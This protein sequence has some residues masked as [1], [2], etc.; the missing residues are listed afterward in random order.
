MDKIVCELKSNPLYWASLGS[1]ELF[2]SNFLG[3]IFEQYPSSVKAVLEKKIQ[4]PDVLRE[5][6][7][8][9]L[10]L[11]AESSIIAI[12]NKFKDV[13]KTK[14]LLEYT[15]KLNTNYHQK[16]I[17]KILLTLVEP[18]NEIE[19][20]MTLLYSD[21]ANRLEKWSKSSDEE[22]SDKHLNYLK[23]YIVLVKGI[24]K[25][26]DEFR[27]QPDYWFNISKKEHFVSLKEIRFEDTILKQLASK[28][29]NDVEHELKSEFKGLKD[30]KS[31]HSGFMM[32]NKKP[33]VD[34]GFST[35]KSPNEVREYDI[36]FSITIEG[37]T[38]RRVIGR[39]DFKLPSKRNDALIDKKL[40][41]LQNELDFEV[42]EW[43]PNWQG[44]NGKNNILNSQ[45]YITSMRAR[46]CSY[47]P[48]YIY[49]YI[50][51]GGD[52]GINPNDLIS[53][54]KADMA[55]A[56]RLVTKIK[57]NGMES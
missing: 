44:E 32:N 19:G 53:H 24:T 10:I 12:E 28:F 38:Y 51:I 41:E 4:K 36:S 55:L 25:I 43:L 26:I 1:R 45:N 5:K 17:E 48:A 14:Q 6:Y 47:R 20:W 22:I 50:N 49:K 2:H 52:N 3:W 7:N 40:L 39:G 35:A 34:F 29:L 31:F 57:A 37:N 16:S 42:S 9:D 54:L 27:F 23:D 21:L 33:M 15:K 18:P 30:D 11:E 46:Y 56:R 8:I 13:P